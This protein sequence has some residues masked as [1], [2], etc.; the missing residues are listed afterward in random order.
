M[1]TAGT[2]MRDVVAIGERVTNELLKL[3]FIDTVGHQIGRAE[4]GEDT[5]SPDRS[6]FHIEL[7][8]VRTETEEE[9]QEKI[10]NALRAFP[11]SAAKR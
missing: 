2:S 8:P 5:W 9:A 10:R 7:K 1:A 6:E 4:L 11:R 3:P